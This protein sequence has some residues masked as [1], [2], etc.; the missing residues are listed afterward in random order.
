M[1]LLRGTGL[2]GARFTFSDHSLRVE[3]SSISANGNWPQLQLKAAPAAAESVEIQIERSGTKL[4]VPYRFDK[5]RA[6]SD[7]MQG[8]SGA[9]SST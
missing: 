9:M 5:A 7:G 6:S 3:R 8:F 4:R 2:T 1:L